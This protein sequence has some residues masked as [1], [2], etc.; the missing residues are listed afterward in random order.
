MTPTPDLIDAAARCYRDGDFALARQHLDEAIAQPDA[1]D[2]AKRIRSG[3]DLLVLVGA[4]DRVWVPEV[5]HWR[6]CPATDSACP[7]GDAECKDEC[8]L[9]A[10]GWPTDGRRCLILVDGEEMA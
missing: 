8:R 6:R 7:N 4:Y 3:K 10:D 9:V 5:A 2:H 1:A